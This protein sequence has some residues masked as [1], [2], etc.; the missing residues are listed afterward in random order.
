[1]RVVSTKLTRLVALWVLWTV[2]G[3]GID[4]TALKPQGYVSDFAGVV[5]AASK[6]AIEAYGTRLEAAT[7]AQIALVTM[8]TLE[9]EPIEDVANNL[10][11]QWGIGKKGTDEGLLFLIVV[12][13]RRTRLE[14]GR[15]LEPIIP[16]GATGTV[17]RAMR[18]ALR[19]NNYGQAR[20]TAR[21]H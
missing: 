14:V 13:D 10:F 2:A 4:L 1:M 16:D 9:G 15:G 11:R 6:Q 12:K 21:R 7:G 3:F 20:A 5:D 19:E 18:P 17:L 8:N